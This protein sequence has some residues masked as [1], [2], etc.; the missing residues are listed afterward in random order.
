VSRVIT[1]SSRQSGV[2]APTG[3]AAEDIDGRSL[4]DNS[5]IVYGGAIADGN[6]HSHDNLPVILAGR[7]GGSLQPGRYLKVPE[8][9][10][11]NLFVSLLNRL[12]IVT[13]LFG[14]ST[15]RLEPV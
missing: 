3:A 14:D 10:M 8:Q 13:D 5:M 2:A 1:T 15:G 7:G 12:D 9:P 4:L 11:A 6:K